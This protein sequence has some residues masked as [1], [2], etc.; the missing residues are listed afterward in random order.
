MEPFPW[1]KAFAVEDK[2][3]DDQH[4]QMVG[5]INQICI[6]VAVARREDSLSLLT[7]LRFVSEKHFRHE[8]ALLTRI[9]AGIDVQPLQISVNAAITEHAR[10]HRQKLGEL[11]KL[12]ERWR[13]TNSRAD[14]LAFCEEL[15]AWF[16]D[17]TI[18]CDAQIKTILQTAWYWRNTNNP[19]QLGG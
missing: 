9:H 16:V 7:N 11:Q 19:R 14:E 8:E 4:R 12:T 13:C 17:Q 1:S 10:E 15:K 5:I 3:L 2:L 18:G 6:S